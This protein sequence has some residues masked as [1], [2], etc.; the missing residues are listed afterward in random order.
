MARAN[1][2]WIALGAFA[3]LGVLEWTTLSAETIRVV[4]GPNGEPLLDISVRGVAL[5]ILGLLA[6]RTWIHHRRQ[7]LEE[8]GR[9]AVSG[10]GRE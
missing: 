3:L 9:S 5:A 2:F 8:R 4:N 1:R 6:F 7:M 10:S